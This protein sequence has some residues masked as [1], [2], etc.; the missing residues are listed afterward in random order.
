MKLNKYL[1]AILL[2]GFCLRILTFF[3]YGYDLNLQSDDANYRVS[4]EVLLKTGMLTYVEHTIPTVHIMP[5]QV[6]L[7]S[8][9]ILLFGPGNA[10]LIATKIMF[11]LLG[12]LSIY[13]LY[14]IGAKLFNEKAG[15]IAAFLLA[16]YLPQVLMD[17]ITLTE[18]PFLPAF[19]ALIYFSLKLVEKK[20]MSTFLIMLLFYFIAL[21][22]R[23][24]IALY[25]VFL[26]IYLLIKKYPFKLMMKQFS[27]S[28]VLLLI[29]MGPWWIRNYAAYN[30]FIPLTGGSGNPLLLGSF[31]GQGITPG[32]Y[33][34]IVEQINKEHPHANK[35]EIMEAQKEVAKERISY[36]WKHNP[37]YFIKS[38]L[39]IK[40]QLLWHKEY[41]PKEIFLPFDVVNKAGNYLK[42]IGFASLIAAFFLLKKQRKELIFIALLLFFQ[43]YFN[44]SI[45]SFNRYALP[46][47]PLLFMA[48][49]GLGGYLIIKYKSKYLESS[50]NSKSTS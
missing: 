49:G 3:I 38:Y 24:Q 1:I 23:V 34:E 31:Y 7:L 6:W 27:V 40:P 9:P 45:L 12:T 33:S 29:V 2:L 16:I 11:I 8:L 20:N 5:G 43:T 25:P 48:I 36:W 46:M 30:Q 22:L 17:N 37:K 44:S 19:L 14:K 15:L 26:F 21:F 10:S 28:V 13:L 47:M 4:A 42:V 39:Y 41:F 50:S 32:N 35:Y 18:S